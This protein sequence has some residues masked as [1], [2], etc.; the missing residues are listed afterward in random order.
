MTMGKTR[1]RVLRASTKRTVDTA[2]ILGHIFLGF[3][4]DINKAYLVFCGLIML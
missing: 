1:M 4:L 3:V 2:L